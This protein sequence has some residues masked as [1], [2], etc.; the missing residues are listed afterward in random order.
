MISMDLVGTVLMV[1]MHSAT[2]VPYIE[3]PSTTLVSS[4]SIPRLFAT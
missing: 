3:I 2:F 4:N 1:V